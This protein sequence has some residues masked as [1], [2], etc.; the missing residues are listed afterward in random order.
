[1]RGAGGEMLLLCLM[2]LPCLTRPGICPVMMA[3]MIMA[4]G[5]SPH[6][7]GSMV[8]P[9]TVAATAVRMCS[10]RPSHHHDG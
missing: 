4:V 6:G 7:G 5:S 9:F 8:L 3:K 10:G 1:M 2:L